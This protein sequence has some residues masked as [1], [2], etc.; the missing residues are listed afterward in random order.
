VSGTRFQAEIA[1]AW[2]SSEPR[3]GSAAAGQGRAPS[4]SPSASR[5]LEVVACGSGPESGAGSSTRGAP[6]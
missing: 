4:S 1:M 5:Q 6:T 2:N 3:S